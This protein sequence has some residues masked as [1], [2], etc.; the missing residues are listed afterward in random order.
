VALSFDFSFEFGLLFFIT[1]NC[2]AK[3]IMVMYFNSSKNRKIT[4]D[5]LVSELF[6]FMKEAPGNH[7]RVII[8]TDSEQRNNFDDFVS[9]VIIHRVG[10]GGRY[11]WRRV[12]LKKSKALRQRIYQEVSLS[13]EVAQKLVE[14]LKYTENFDFSFEIHV[15][16]GVNGASKVMIQEVVSIVRGNGFKVK[17]KPESFGASNVADRYL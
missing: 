4:L 10:K 15:D 9:A 14:K 7:Y 6:A 17:T 11:F 1:R 2:F 3:G 12:S 16:V 8:G 13:L 5:K